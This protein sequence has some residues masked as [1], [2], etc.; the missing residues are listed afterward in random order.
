MKLKVGANSNGVQKV[1]LFLE[2]DNSNYNHKSRNRR[3]YGND[4]KTHNEPPDYSSINN[5]SKVHQTFF[6][7]NKKKQKY[8]YLLKISIVR[9]VSRYDIKKE[10]KYSQS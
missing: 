8:D 3:C 9:N 1:C 4:K 10:K 6:C 7:E 2:K 5:V